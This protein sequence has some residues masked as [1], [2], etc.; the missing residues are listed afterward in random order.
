MLAILCLF[1][2]SVNQ[3]LNHWWWLLLERLQR[4]CRNYRAVIRQLLHEVLPPSLSTPMW[5]T[6]I[7]FDVDGA[8]WFLTRTVSMTQ[9]AVMVARI[10]QS[11][12]V[13]AA[14][15]ISGSCI[16]KDT[17]ALATAVSLREWG[18]HLPST[19]INEEMNKSCLDEII[20]ELSER[21][22]DWPYARLMLE[23]DCVAVLAIG[24]RISSAIVLPFAAVIG[25]IG[26]FIEKQL[27]SR[28][29]SIPYL[30]TSVHDDRMRRQMEVEL[31]PEY[32]TEHTLKEEKKR[33]VPKSSLLLNTGRSGA[34]QHG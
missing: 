32:K 24:T 19:E 2:W 16:F 25:T 31:D 30:D 28:P 18:H 29:K 33:I 7:L 22:S 26:Y 6:F 1:Q 9:G 27:S 11:V 13:Q 5:P 20:V 3:E 23:H 4:I 17:V 15:A 12:D 14:T 21:P 34:A 8:E 10:V